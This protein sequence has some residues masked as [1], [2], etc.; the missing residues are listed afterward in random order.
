LTLL[1]EDFEAKRYLLPPAQPLEVLRFLLDQHDPKPQD[2]LDVFGTRRIVAE[3]LG[4]KRKLHKD[5]SAR[6]SRRFH[7]SPEVFF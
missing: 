1:V 6:L 2:L 5:H 4:G 7:V 3:V